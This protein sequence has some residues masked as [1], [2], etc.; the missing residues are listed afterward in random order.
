MP[1][2]PLVTLIGRVNVGKS[3]LFNKL[4]DERKALESPIAGTTRDYNQAIIS[5]RKIQFSLIDTGGFIDTPQ[6]EIAKET[7]K[8]TKKQTNKADLLVLVVDHKE[9]LTPMD[10]EL[11]TRAKKYHKPIIIAIN[12]VDKPHERDAAV[13]EF[14][15]LGADRLLPLSAM[16]GHGVGDFLDTIASL[17]NTHPE[18]QTLLFP[19]NKKEQKGM[20]KLAIVGQPNVGK[21]SLLNTLI[22]EQRAIV[23]STPHTT[24]DAHD[25]II[26]WGRHSFQ[27]IDTAGIRRRK[28]KG[29]LV[30]KFSIDIALR[31]L[32][33]SHLALLVIDVSQHLTH[34]DKHLGEKIIDTGNSAVIIANKW[35]LVPEKETN[36]INEY[37]TYI[38]SQLPHLSWAPIVFTSALTK[39]YADTILKISLSVWQERFRT[40]SDNALDTFIKK[41]VKKHRPS[42]GKGVAH[43]Y[44]YHLRQTGV[45]P[46][47]FLLTIKYQKSLHSSYINFIERQLYHQFGFNG[48]PIKINIKALK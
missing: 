8:Q 17:L 9:G 31:T 25:A 15:A 11:F 24:R 33:K 42:R 21:S 28:R 41:I 46:P 12:K 37:E 32:R 5:W 38:R 36:T 29:D 18:R 2:L 16:S 35:D 47:R 39:K 48:T 4:A 19:D 40:I 22:G 45:N 14:S 30:E 3:T 44:I 26:S 27:I 7:S 10:T 43:P 20:V 1:H 6:E 23:S 13:L 34:Q